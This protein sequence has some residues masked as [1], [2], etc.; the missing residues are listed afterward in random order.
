[1]VE[2]E[3]QSEAVVSVVVVVTVASFQE[4]AVIVVDIEAASV[5]EAM[6]HTDCSSLSE[7]RSCDGDCAGISLSNASEGVGKRTI[8]IRGFQPAR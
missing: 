5:D 3:A 7:N 6:C 2:A 4:E 8:V 1:M